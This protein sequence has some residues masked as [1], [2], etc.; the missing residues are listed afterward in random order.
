MAAGAALLGVAGGLAATN[1]KRRS[2][3]L[4]GG[5]GPKLSLPKPS[6]STSGL[7]KAMKNV[8]LPK[9]DASAIDW[10]EK[11]AKDVGDAGYRVAEMTSQA[12]RVRKALSGG[13]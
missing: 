3:F 13:D 12:Q 9:L 1:G 11:K 8:D 6:V 2:G 4:P 7:Q 10:V 5:R